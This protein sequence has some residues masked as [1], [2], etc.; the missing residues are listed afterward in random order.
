MEK[1]YRDIQTRGQ[2]AGL[3]LLEVFVLVGVPLLLFPFLTLLDINFA[4]ILLI[5]IMLYALFRLAGKISGFDY[6]LISFVLYNYKW[7][8]ELSAF[9][10]DERQYLKY[11]LHKTKRK[12]SI[13]IHERYR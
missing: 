10:L 4:I 6:G 8:R 1:C 3:S 9:K 13:S 2:I 7:P 12:R 11:E 5:E